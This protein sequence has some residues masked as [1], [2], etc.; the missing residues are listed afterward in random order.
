MAC[1]DL[2]LALIDGSKANRIACGFLAVTAPLFTQLSANLISPQLNVR[3]DGGGRLLLQAPDLDYCAN[4]AAPAT[5]QGYV[6]QEVL[7]R[8]CR[9]FNN[10]ESAKIEHI[11]VGQRSRPV[12]GLQGIGYV[13]PHKRIYL[14]VAHS[15]MTH[16][17]LLGR[18][19][20]H[21]MLTGQRAELLHD[22]L[23]ERLLGKSTQNFPTFSAL[24]FPA[25]Q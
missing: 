12:D 9:L 5:V 1:L 11:A 4:P 3:P 16:G 18:L 15:G 19:V 6:G 23:P 25:A 17:P 14:M 20:A 2:E 22:F 24:H 21:E 7:N 8:L 10:S 13:T